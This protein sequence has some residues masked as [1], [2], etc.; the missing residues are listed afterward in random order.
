MRILFLDDD[1]YRHKTVRPLM[2]FDAARTA[3]EAIGLLQ[4]N[5][6]DLVFLDHDLGG[7]QMVE[8]SEENT[9]F[10]VAKWIRDNNP[11]IGWVILHSLNPGGVLNMDSVL[12]QADYSTLICPFTR[13]PD[14]LAEI[15]NAAKAL[16]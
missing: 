6:Y 2:T 11:S 13:L 16:R 5:T 4:V 8:S 3:L 7:L 12:R 9:G 15:I 14:K 10:T 1:E